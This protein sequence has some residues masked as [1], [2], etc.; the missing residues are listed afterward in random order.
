MVHFV[1]CFQV[2]EADSGQSAS[3]QSQIGC[4]D[5]LTVIAISTIS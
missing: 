3:Q 4:R 2:A 1:I 5:G